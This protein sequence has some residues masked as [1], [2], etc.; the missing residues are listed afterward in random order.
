[1][2]RI[3]AFGYGFGFTMLAHVIQGTRGHWIFG[4]ELLHHGQGMPK[5]LEVCFVDRHSDGCAD[6]SEPRN[7]GNCRVLFVSSFF[8]ES[9]WDTNEAHQ[10]DVSYLPANTTICA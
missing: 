5:T 10:D 7:N 1:M 3:L 2:H 4:R 6:H 8:T 9:C